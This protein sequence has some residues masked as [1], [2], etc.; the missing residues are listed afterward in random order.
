[1]KVIESKTGRTSKKDIIT[2]YKN[3]ISNPYFKKLLDSVPNIV[4]IINSNRQIIF[5]NNVM[6]EQIKIVSIED[7]LGLR[8]GESIDCKNSDIAETGCGDCENCS[9][10]GANLAIRESQNKKITV[11]NECRITSDSNNGTNTSFEFAVTVTPLEWENQYYSIV[12]LNDVSNSKRR[13]MLER[14]FLHDIINKIGSLNCYLELIK[15]TKGSE[16]GDEFLKGAIDLSKDLTDDIISQRELISAEAKSLVVE[17][18]FLKTKDIIGVVVNQITHHE[19]AS[20]K[21]VVIDINTVNETISTDYSLIKRILINLLKNALEASLPDETI[22]I[23]C[24]KNETEVIFWVHNPGY[25]KRETELQIFQRSFSTKGN[26]RGLGTYRIK[27]LTEQYLGGK[28]HFTTNE[29]NGTKFNILLK[30]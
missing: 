10:C 13:L 2:D 25:M 15:E 7:I 20:E 9:Y 11:T 12:S 30:K 23:G 19:V 27:L 16:K 24:N 26:N 22:T 14:V 29:K 1:M 4:A 28:V 3:I 6:L 21:H 5:S 18:I 8:I 17:N